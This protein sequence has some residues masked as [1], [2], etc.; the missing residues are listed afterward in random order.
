MEQRWISKP[1]KPQQQDNNKQGSEEKVHLLTPD[2]LQPY[3]TFPGM[4]V[5]HTQPEWS[6]YEVMRR[7]W[8]HCHPIGSLRPM[9]EQSGE[10]SYVRDT[11]RTGTH[12][13]GRVCAH[14]TPVR[15]R[16][17]VCVY[18][19]LSSQAKKMTNVLK[20]ALCQLS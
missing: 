4:T 1:K 13:A 5:N 11:P 15:A 7:P 20:G 8:S 12:A 3:Y 2:T 17:C 19:W 6:H 16:A 9:V 10:L 18:V 14:V